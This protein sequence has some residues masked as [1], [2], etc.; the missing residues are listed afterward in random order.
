LEQSWRKAL[1][2]PSAVPRRG[3]VIKD[4]DLGNT[5]DLIV[6]VIVGF[7]GGSLLYSVPR[8]TT[9]DASTVSTS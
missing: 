7:G 9:G 3:K 8:A 4:E 1:E 6:G 2:A 5:G